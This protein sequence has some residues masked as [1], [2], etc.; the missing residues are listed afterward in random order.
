MAGNSNN[1]AQPQKPFEQKK[2]E[3]NRSVD[4]LE[5]DKMEQE[6]ERILKMTDGNLMTRS[7]LAEGSL[8]GDSVIVREPE[9]TSTTTENT[10]KATQ[11]QLQRQTS[12]E[13]MDEFV[14]VEKEG[15]AEGGDKLKVA[16]NAAGSPGNQL[17]ATGELEGSFHRIRTSG[18][19]NLSFWNM[20][21]GTIDPGR[22][23]LTN[24]FL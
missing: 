9:H 13:G 16:S 3:V 1:N 20:D 2:N 11:P 18:E 4:L 12:E 15:E 17:A 7:G 22:F 10:D 19:I 5:E 24:F 14:V 21:K 8:L 6:M 23:F